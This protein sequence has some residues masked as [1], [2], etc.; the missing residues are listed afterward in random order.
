MESMNV[1]IYS[2]DVDNSYCLMVC[3]KHGRSPKILVIAMITKDLLQGIMS[4]S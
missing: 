4:R 3:K 2:Y 1:G